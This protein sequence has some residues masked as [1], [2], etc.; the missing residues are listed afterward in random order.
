MIDL[1]CF[2][3]LGGEEEEFVGLRPASLT[4]RD[5]ESR[6]VNINFYVS[7]YLKAK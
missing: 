1:F 6:R 7:S 5:A 2:S 4:R 3:G